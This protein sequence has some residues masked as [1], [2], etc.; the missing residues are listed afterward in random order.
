MENLSIENQSFEWVRTRTYSPT[1]QIYKGNNEFLRIGPESE[2][3]QELTRHAELS[4]LGFPIAKILKEDVHGERSYYIEESIGETIL[5]KIF[6]EDY[7]RQKRINDQHFNEFLEVIS[8]Y[9]NAQLKSAKISGNFDEFTKGFFLDVI[10]KERPDLKD[11]L[12][13]VF[14]KVKERIGELPFVL[15][16]GDFNA[17]NLFPKGVIDLEDFHYGPLGY[18]LTSAIVHPYLFPPVSV[19]AESN[20]TYQFTPEQEVGYF[21]KMDTIFQANNL[22]PFTNYLDEFT[23]CRAIFASAEMHYRPLVQKWRYDLLE[24]LMNQYLAGEALN[25]SAST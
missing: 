20:R 5:G 12:D 17:H 11:L 14:T 18:D 21:S 8:R 4:A 6:A 22:K 9:A 23:L 10:Y 13:A 3:K 16:H 15:T 2:I 25:L 19:N 7:T 24:K 1:Y